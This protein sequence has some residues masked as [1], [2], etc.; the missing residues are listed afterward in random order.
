[1]IKRILIPAFFSCFFS[2]GFAQTTYTFPPRVEVSHIQTGM[3]NSERKDN[4]DFFQNYHESFHPIG[5]SENGKAAY[6]VWSEGEFG[7][8]FGVVVYDVVSDSVAGS[9][10]LEMGETADLHEDQVALLWKQHADSIYPLLRKHKIV[11]QA[12]ANYADLPAAFS[13]RKFSV[14]F[15]PKISPMDER[16][17]EGVKGNCM[18]TS[19]NKTDTVAFHWT[20]FYDVDIQPA[21]IWLSPTEKYAL[22]VIVCET[23]GQHGD[24]PPR[25]IRYVFRS[26]KL[27]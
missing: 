3:Q 12:R 21:G 23:G 22:V 7:A 20:G 26:L 24:L 6:L 11:Q 14:E 5:W 13:S 19:G 18:I 4:E 2:I 17:K 25:N 16:F 27:P 8:H 9:W 1:M 10:F 15:A